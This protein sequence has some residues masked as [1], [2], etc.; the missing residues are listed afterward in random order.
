M[1]PQEQEALSIRYGDGV[2]IVA[3]LKDGSYA[4]FAN[5]RTMESMLIITNPDELVLAITS[6]SNMIKRKTP[7]KLVRSSVSTDGLFDD[8]E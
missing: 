8:D 3:P 1:T 4:V 5:D 6:R 7:S 2:A